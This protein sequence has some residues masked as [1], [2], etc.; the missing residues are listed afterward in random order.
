[1]F[2]EP[3]GGDLGGFFFIRGDADKLAALRVDDDF[4]AVIQKADPDRRQDGRRRGRDG[5]R[6]SSDRWTQLRGSDRAVRIG[7][8]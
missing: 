6:V 2:L 3:H 8:T 5:R 1:M 7:R 4:D